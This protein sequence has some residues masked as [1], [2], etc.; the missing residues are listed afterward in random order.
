MPGKCI[1]CLNLQ[2]RWG[3]LLPTAASLH[4]I[5][6]PGT[7]QSSSRGNANTCTWG[8]NSWEL[9]HVVGHPD[10]KKLGRER[11]GALSVCACGKCMKCTLGCIRRGIASSSRVSSFSS[12]KHSLGL[13]MSAVSISGL[14]QKNHGHT[15]E[16]PAKDHKDDERTGTLLWEIA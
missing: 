12:T 6:Y 1:K 14:V 2:C 10:G 15:K 13:T 11:P 8:G 16:S 5:F 4:W 7:S 9:V 3:L